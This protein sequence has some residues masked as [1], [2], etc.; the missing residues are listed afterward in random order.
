MSLNR[1]TDIIFGKDDLENIFKLDK[2]PVFMGCMD[3]MNSKNDLYQDFVID[4]S[5]SSGI[6]QVRNLI[7]LEVLYDSDHSSGTVGK[8]WHDHHRAFARFIETK[9]KPSK[10]FEIGGLHGILSKYYSDKNKISSWKIVEPN[11]IPVEGC[12]AEFIKCFFGND[13]E[14]DEEFDAYVHSHTLEHIY[15]PIEFA[16]KL[17]DFIPENKDLYFSVPNIEEMIKRKYTNA[18][19]FEHTFLLTRELATYIMESNGFKFIESRDFMDDHSI[20]YH[21]KKQKSSYEKTVKLEN[22]YNHNKKLMKDWYRHH[23]LEAKNLV[24]IINKND[25][26][27]FLFGAHIFSQTLLNFGLD[28]SYIDCIL[29]NDSNKHGK[30]LYGTDLVVKSPEIIKDI[31]KPTIIL[32][33][34]VY[35]D[36]IREQILSINPSA[37]IV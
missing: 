37:L 23:N 10:V 26:N 25:S 31:N 20:F 8:I 29:D 5:K 35:N 1:K 14:L 12:P 18:I 33:A 28:E 17:S 2:F 22:K 32:R 7:E 36:E 34:G 3:D 4:I 27:V 30:R 6:V 13:F 16:K 9:T 11:P 19:N 15:N 21:F 24:D